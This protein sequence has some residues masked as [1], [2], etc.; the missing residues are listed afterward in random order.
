MIIEIAKVSAAIAVIAGFWAKVKSAYTKLA[1]L[2]EP[3]VKDVEQRAKDGAIDRN[4]RKEI[5][6]AVIV[7]AQLRGDLRKFG[8]IEGIIVSRV[9]DWVAGKLPD[10]VLTKDVILK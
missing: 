5:A 7:N 10:F 6:M 1:P 2:I 3:F 4:D 8:F 9:V